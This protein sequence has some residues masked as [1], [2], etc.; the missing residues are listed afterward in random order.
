MKITVTLDLS[1]VEQK[2]L[3][4]NSIERVINNSKRRAL[5]SESSD[6]RAQINY[7]DWENL[8]PLTNKLWWA[9]RDA[10]FQARNKK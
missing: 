9:T 8:G 4:Q 7:D 3:L 2:A 10:V 5:E 1:E 6:D